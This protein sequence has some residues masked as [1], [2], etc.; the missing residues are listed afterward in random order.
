MKVTSQNYNRIIDALGEKN[1]PA[2]FGPA[3]QWMLTRNK[4]DLSKSLIE[5]TTNAYFAKLT[6]YINARHP[7]LWSSLPAR[8]GKSAAKA[9]FKHRSRGKKQAGKSVQSDKPGNDNIE[10]KGNKPSKNSSV[11]KANSESKDSKTSK[12]RQVS[13]DKPKKAAAKKADTPASADNERVK[14]TRKLSPE[15]D[16]IRKYVNLHNKHKSFGSIKN[17]MKGLNDAI[18]QQLIRKTSPYAKEIQYIQKDIF[19]NLE[20]AA[21]KGKEFIT[22]S[23]PQAVLGEYIQLAGGEKVFASIGL[24]RSYMNLQ[25]T[26]P[27]RAKVENLLKRMER[28]ELGDDPFADELK[29]MAKNLRRYLD[30]PGD[31]PIDIEKSELS[32]LAG[33]A[34][35]LAV[36]KKSERMSAH[37]LEGHN[38]VKEGFTGKWKQ[39]LGNPAK[40]FKLM[41]YGPPGQGKSTLA[42][43]L[44]RELAQH[45]G[46]VLYLSAEEHGSATLQEKVKRVGGAVEGWHFDSR[47]PADLH[48]FDY[49]FIDSVNRLGFSLEEFRQIADECH[50]LAV[51]YIM[52]VTK[53]GVFK[54][55]ADWEHEADIVVTMANGVAAA[56]KNRYKELTEIEIF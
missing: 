30:R 19:A 36:K 24:M 48:K 27:E 33:L 4:K 53:T 55:K 3:H 34:G 9:E 26:R 51:V 16:F 39:L 15:V 32:G 44:A 43:M 37:E 56:Q 20:E 28:A 46:D 25:G 50:N 8:T 14:L 47:I 54:G 18:A 1:L 52:Q 6:D 11:R 49:L 38:Y 45:H 10:D 29:K 41:I 21:R 35:L 12:A 7:Q 31:Q 5:A 2:A 40:G 23:V 42:L 22:Y 13:K 17:L